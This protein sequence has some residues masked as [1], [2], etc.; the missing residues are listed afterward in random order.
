MRLGWEKEW[1]VL[2]LILGHHLLGRLPPV[3]PPQC[4][5]CPAG[6]GLFMLSRRRH[7]K[8]PS[9]QVR[10][11]VQ[12]VTKPIAALGRLF[13]PIL[14]KRGGLRLL[15]REKGVTILELLSVLEVTPFLDKVLIFFTLPPKVIVVLTSQEE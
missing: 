15:T 2:V 5:Q 11:W 7:L 1:K 8:P 3:T 9:S 6:E 10:E 14:L 13:F 12:Q 4:P